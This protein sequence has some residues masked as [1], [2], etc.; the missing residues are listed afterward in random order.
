MELH[1]IVSLALV[2]FFVLDSYVDAKKATKFSIEIEKKIDA[3]KCKIKSKNGDYLH[4]HY[5]V[6]V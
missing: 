6:S 3:D 1:N 2:A 4:M 5:T